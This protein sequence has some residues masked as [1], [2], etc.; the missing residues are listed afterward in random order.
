[1]VTI[2]SNLWHQDTEFLLGEIVQS[3]KTTLRSILTK[4]LS[5]GLMILGL[6]KSMENFR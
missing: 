5:K 1:M 4:E 2:G 6:L 3:F